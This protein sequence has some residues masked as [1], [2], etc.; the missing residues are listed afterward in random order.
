[1]SGT[2]RLSDPAQAWLRSSSLGAS[3]SQD[4]APLG[5]LA[6]A[7]P[8]PSSLGASVSQGAAPLDDL[9]LTRLLQLCSPIL[10]VG[11]YSYS[12]GLESAVE[13]GSV[14]DRDSAEV[15]IGDSLTLVV[16]RFEAPL[17]CRLYQAWS[18][19][20]PTRAEFWNSYFL[21]SRETAEL[22]A[23]T[24]QMGYSLVRL[25]RDCATFDSSALALL[26]SI[27]PI[28]FPAAFS[29]ACVQWKIAQ[30][31]AL[32]GYLWAWL[33]N[34]VM[35]AIKAVP[36]GQVAGQSILLALAQSVA[37][38]ADRALSLEE[39]EMSNLAPGLALASSAHEVQYSRIF[40][41]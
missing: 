32:I 1:M 9:A 39:H 33:E 29:F 36:L 7:Q 2:V 28:S 16:G 10:P 11:A 19:A 37:R 34:Q 13:F 24:E 40:R 38:V 6:L 21:A 8:G 22:R 4:T 14:V 30:R 41:S 18:E 5:D 31:Q 26:A 23:E 20:E 35:A 3:V 17:W 15:W 27:E 12:Q 25:A